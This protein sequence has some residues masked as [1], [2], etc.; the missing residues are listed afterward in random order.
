MKILQAIISLGCYILAAIYIV[1]AGFGFWPEISAMES[2][3]WACLVL[4]LILTM[5]D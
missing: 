4:L 2:L 3:G 5:R 1:N